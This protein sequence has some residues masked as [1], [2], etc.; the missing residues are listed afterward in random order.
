LLDEE[1]EPIEGFRLGDWYM[2]HTADE[3]DRPVK[4]RGKSD[5]S[6]LVG[7]PVRPRVVFWDADLYAIQF[8]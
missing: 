6:T 1:G 4:W 3:L 8:R 2:I 7:K 5:V